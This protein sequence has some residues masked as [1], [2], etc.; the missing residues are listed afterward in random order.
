MQYPGCKQ[1]EGKMKEATRITEIPIR[2]TRASFLS[3]ELLKI[4]ETFFV[5]PTGIRATPP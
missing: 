1:M 5:L 3:I 2:R 4:K